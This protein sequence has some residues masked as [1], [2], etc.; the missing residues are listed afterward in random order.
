MINICI[1]TLKRYDLL[2]DCI[3]S[4]ESGNLKPDNYFIVDNGTRFIIP[5]ELMNLSIYIYNPGMNIGVAKAW[6]IFLTQ[7]PEIRVICNDDIEFYS[8]SLEKL[9]NSYS[10]KFITY[11]G[12]IQQ[13]NSFSCFVLSD[14]IIK[15]VG[16]FDEDISPNYGYFEDN[17]YHYRM[18]LKGFDLSPVLNCSIGHFKSATL[19]SYDKQELA[20]HHRRFNL[21][22]NNYIRKWGGEP[23]KETK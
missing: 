16:L 3:K 17:D 1:P 11:P 9:V 7:I 13:S 22:K 10:T 8:D 14:G 23:G 12:G 6:N 20:F 18:K 4:L 2:I 5:D 21:A 15:E 19:K